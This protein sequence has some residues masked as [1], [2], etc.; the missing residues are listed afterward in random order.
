MRLVF[1][2]AGEKIEIIRVQWEGLPEIERA[3]FV[4][5]CSN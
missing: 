5:K 1:Q 2:K 3:V 4:E